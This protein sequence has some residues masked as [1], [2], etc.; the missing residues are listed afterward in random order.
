VDLDRVELIH[1]FI[2][3]NLELL[4][5]SPFRQAEYR[6]KKQQYFLER[7]GNSKQGNPR[8]SEIASETVWFLIRRGGIQ[9]KEQLDKV[10]SSGLPAEKCPNRE[11]FDEA[12]QARGP[13]KA[14]IDYGKVR[15]DDFLESLREQIRGQLEKELR[16]QGRSLQD[17][18]TIREADRI[19]KERL[20]MIASLPSVIDARDFEEPA[21]PPE[22][23]EADERLLWWEKLNLTDDP[24]KQKEGLYDIE[25]ERYDDVV[26]KTPLFQQY[27]RYMDEIPQELFKNTIL[28]GEYGSGKTAFFQYLK[29]A[30]DARQID[31]VIVSLSGYPNFQA[32]KSAFEEKLADELRDLMGDEGETTS[33]KVLMRKVGQRPKFKGLVVFI[34]NMNKLREDTPAALTFLAYLQVYRNEL[35]Q[36]V[37]G[38][39]GFYVAGALAWQDT[40]KSEP[41]YSGSL[42]RR[43]VIPAITADQAIEMLNRRLESYYPNPDVKRTVKREFVEQVYKNLVTHNEELTF[44]KFMERLQIEFEDNDFTVLAADPVKIPEEILSNIRTTFQSDPVL[45]ERF[46]TL[47]ED[48]IKVNQ[49][50][51]I[52]CIRLLAEIFRRERTKRMRDEDFDEGKMFYLKM[53]EKAVLVARVDEGNHQHSWAVCPELERMNKAIAARYSL[54]LDDYLLKIYGASRAS[55]RKTNEELE[56]IR[57][58]S[59]ECEAESRGLL[60]KVLTLHAEISEALEH[61]TEKATKPEILRKC[62]DSL[63][64]LTQFYA[65]YVERPEETALEQVDLMFWKDFWYFPEEIA[66]F[67]NRISDE[68]ECLEHIWNTVG[69]YGQAFK[70]LSRFVRKEYRALS[71]V[72]ISSHGLNNEDI[73]ALVNARDRWMGGESELCVRALKDHIQRKTRTFVQNVMTLIYGDFP[74]RLKHMDVKSQGKIQAAIDSGKLK[75]G[76]RF[77]E[78][79]LLS[80]DDLVTLMTNSHGGNSASCWEYVFK[81]IFHP[82]TIRD[83]ERYKDSL[84]KLSITSE[85]AAES[86]EDEVLAL[87]EIITVTVDMTRKMNAGYDL[88]LKSVFLEPAGSGTNLYLSLAELSD[89]SELPVLQ[90]QPNTARMLVEGLSSGDLALDD[91]AFIQDYYAKSLSYREFFVY[92]AL[93]L[94]PDKATRL[95][96]IISYSGSVH[97]SHLRL[98]KIFRLSSM[99]PPRVFLAYSGKDESFAERLAGDLRR[100]GVTVWTDDFNLKEVDPINPG[101]HEPPKE[102]DLLMV[103]LSRNAID[104]DW[105]KNELTE[106]SVKELEKRKV[107][108]RPVLYKKCDIPAA[109]AGKTPIDFI[110]NYQKGLES[111]LAI[112]EESAPEEVEY[113]KRIDVVGQKIGDLLN[114]TLSQRMSLNWLFEL[115]DKGVISKAN[116]RLR[117][118]VPEDPRTHA[119]QFLTLGELRDALRLDKIWPIMRPI[120]VNTQGS[121]SS[122]KFNT[123]E[124]FFGNFDLLIAYRNPPSHGID[125]PIAK[126]NVEMIQASL[127]K[128]EGILGIS[129]VSPR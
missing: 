59:E 91:P 6:R 53:L 124:L 32:F 110:F 55:R 116:N 92:L 87:R 83:L 20:D 118:K 36:E 68:E 104:S 95:G 26:V 17:E 15:R 115:L 105:I 5:T 56:Q 90:F 18:E 9:T 12:L 111:V 100:N 112:L 24:F 77:N 85:K 125:V 42:L 21:K 50:N 1:G 96:L 47:L 51:R 123:D 34:D 45:K 67:Q 84:R 108:L 126:G 76:S 7:H 66:E 41:R 70:V 106:T 4:T 61:Y 71:T 103:V 49:E 128:L 127:F 121:S 60:S 40:I 120:F 13:R 81:K 63:N 122:L 80:F 88:L 86:S 14:V 98:K 62:V 22:E 54:S 57:V 102:K 79:D 64:A 58:F 23:P 35:A 99:R 107:E 89:K 78:I 2:R 29:K 117:D 75:R 82:T 114:Q 8:D 25:P 113:N 37:S 28:F 72:Q 44:R 16:L 3:E 97:G 30:M 11:I 31:S 101:N 19:I 69:S 48:G 74:N 38:K 27:L 33:L 129:S 93:A 10:L 39:L 94:D 73:K 119:Y 109:L 65:T 43:E 46:R 52:Y